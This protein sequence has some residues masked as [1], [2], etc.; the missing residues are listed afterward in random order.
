MTRCGAV[1]AA[2]A[3]LHCDKQDDRSTRPAARGPQT[4]NRSPPNCRSRTHMASPCLWIAIRTLSDES[5]IAQV[6]GSDVRLRCGVSLAGS[7]LHEVRDTVY[8]CRCATGMQLLVASCSHIS[9]LG[10]HA[11]HHDVCSRAAR[12]MNQCATGACVK[13]G[14]RLAARSTP[15][16]H[17]QGWWQGCRQRMLLVRGPRDASGAGC[18]TREPS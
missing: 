10:G 17:P 11:L 5:D 4:S 18:S 9:T 3:R 12:G 13:F 6:P 16:E 7:T 2:G 14:H 8:S 15:P 1:R